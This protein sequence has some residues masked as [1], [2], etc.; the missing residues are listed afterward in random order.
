M[1]VG[2]AGWTLGRV[3]HLYRV[4]DERA[5]SSR[6]E[7]LSVSIH[8][9][10]VPR[11]QITDDEPRADDLS[12][13]K[14]CEP[15]DIILNRMRA[16]QGAIGLTSSAGLVSP[17]YIVLRPAPSAE[18]RFLHHLFRSGWFVGEMVARLRGIGSVAQGNVRT[19]RINAED[20][21]DIQMW[22]PPLEAQRA[23]AEFLDA[24]TARIDA[25]IAKKRRLIALVSDRFEAQVRHV[26]GALDA[27]WLPLKRRWRVIDCK[28]RTPSYLDDGYPVVSPGDATP[29][30]L[31]LSRA[32]RFV[33]EADY[34]DL[35]EPPRRPDRG[36]I[37]YSRNASIGIAS[38]VDTDE[39]FCMGQ[40]V[41]LITS[42]DQDQLFLTY[43]LNSVGVD[44]L[45]EAKI[46]STFNR[47]NVAQILEVS[48]PCP[49][50]ELQHELSRRFDHLSSLT[51]E[52]RSSLARQI[53][54][55]VEHR[56]AL[57]TAAVTGELA[58]PGVAA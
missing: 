47:V 16:F 26:L 34:L 19:P 56:Q 10:V 28:H 21:G 15:G 52:A 27:P 22:V 36:T 12:S 41:C 30:R 14:R 45:D 51:E 31:D 39:R 55:L 29:G 23:I 3:R 25:L 40:D 8:L 50:P 33:S 46:G 48:V 1:T 44:Q 42:S 24:E 6:P 13:Y 5:G 43:V 4:I 32:H 58:V 37:I 35:A 49:D 17:D 54:L 11:S 2:E 57:I 38:Y 7:L 18:G 20:L 53:D 9:G